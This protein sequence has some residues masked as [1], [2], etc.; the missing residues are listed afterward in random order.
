MNK[1]SIYKIIRL[2]F[3]LIVWFVAG[4]LLQG[5]VPFAGPVET[6][7]RLWKDIWDV[8]FWYAIWTTLSAISLG[9]VVSLFFAT[10]LGY[11]AYIFPKVEYF[12]HPVM[13]LLR[14][15]PMISFTL[16]AIIWSDSSI[17]AFE[18]SVF[19]SLPIIYKQTVAALNNGHGKR[20]KRLKDLKAGLGTKL[21]LA[22]EP[23]TMPEYITGCHRA[24]NM[25][26]KSGII[27]QMLGNT[28]HSIGSVLY[29]AR[30]ELDI[31][32]IFSWTI[33]IIT[34]SVVFEYIILKI[35]SMQWINGRYIHIDDLYEEIEDEDIAL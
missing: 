13:E 8:D 7:V 3:W 10:I 27:A 28:R 19:L 34:C 21:I 5:K 2:I 18:V 4:I 29:Q 15:T 1:N 32:A 24:L 30:D 25:C 11:I 17:L 23:A 26:W 12:L 6:I 16:L 14:Y 22:Y 20:L 33:V 31:A 35:M 9:F